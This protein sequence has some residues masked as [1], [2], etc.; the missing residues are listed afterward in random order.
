MG[1][2]K[3]MERFVWLFMPGALYSADP[4]QNRIYLTFDDGPS[5]QVTPKVLDILGNFDAKATFFILPSN[6]DWWGEIMQRIQVEGHLIALHGMHHHSRYRLGNA[7]LLRELAELND[8][9]VRA[10]LKPSRLYR[11]PFG[12]LRPDTAW[13]LRRQGYRIVFW[14]GMAG[15]YRPDSADVVF[16]RALG[17]MR[18]GAIAVMHDGYRV[19]P[20]S[21]L[22]VLPRLLEVFEQHGWKPA[23][24]AYLDSENE[25]L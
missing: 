24:L 21:I 17:F 10:G 22:E 23:S 7:E 15:D 8:L 2:F 25:A 3:Y 6:E 14:S 16:Q 13:T 1:Y 9:V 5:P 4:N 20:S 11:P 12:H 18:P 19:P